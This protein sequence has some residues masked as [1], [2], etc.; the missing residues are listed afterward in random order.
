MNKF[1]HLV[2]FGLA[3]RIKSKAFIIS[4]T[5]ICLIIIGITLIPTI[6]NIFNNGEDRVIEIE[7]SLLIYNQTN[8]STIFN[9]LE[10]LINISNPQSETLI[11]NYTE[12]VDEVDLGQFYEESN[13]DGLIIIV[14]EASN[15]SIILHNKSLDGYTSNLLYN[16]LPEFARYRFTKVNPEFED[17]I[18]TSPLTIGV[19]PNESSELLEMVMGI[20]PIFILPVFMLI[21]FGVQFIG[22]DIIEEKSTK[23]IEI[24]ISSVKPSIHFLSKITYVLLFLVIQIGLYLVAGLIG[25]LINSLLTGGDSWTALISQLSSLDLTGTLIILLIITI[26]GTLFYLILASFIASLSVNQEDYQQIQ[27]PIMLLLMFGYFGSIFSVLSQST[28][29]INI[30]IYL[31]FVSPLML[32]TAYF[33]GIISIWEVVLSLVVL[34]G[35]TGL[36]IY[37]LAPLYRASILSYDQSKLFKRIRNSYRFSRSNR[38]E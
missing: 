29:L 1:R 33:A 31:P 37:F 38:N 34:V 28:I 32:P 7:Q 24:I 27:T 12:T 2:K 23:A 36:L 25:L 8:D 17:E 6:I 22:V 4:T 11:F 3:K 5:I 16:T 20:G 26:F 9:D 18:A 35:S 19:N 15:Y 13:Y 14:A 10:D 30:L 21:I